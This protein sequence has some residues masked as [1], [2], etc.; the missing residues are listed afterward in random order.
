MER[1]TPGGTV[2]PPETFAGEDIPYN[3]FVK[4]GADE[5]TYL[6]CGAN[7]HAVGVVENDL[8]SHNI[9]DT[10]R[11]GFKRYDPLAIKNSG[12]AI[13]EAGE[14]IELEEL[15]KPGANG[16]AMKYTISTVSD[17]PTQ[18][19]VQA[20]ARQDRDIRG[21]VVKNPA[22]KAGDLVKVILLNMG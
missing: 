13:L 6:K 5:K 20:I 22:G 2:L 11:T 4:I 7:E 10:V 3:R 1:K 15:I 9:D 12:A 21:I 18:A 14:A 8:L 19:Q 16:V 17:P